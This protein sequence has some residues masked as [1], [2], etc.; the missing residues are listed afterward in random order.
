MIAIAKG[1][2]ICWLTKWSTIQVMTTTKPKRPETNKT[3]T[4]PDQTYNTTSQIVS[5]PSNN[6]T[7]GI[8][9]TTNTNAVGNNSRLPI[10]FKWL[11]HKR[12]FNVAN[13]VHFNY[14]YKTEEV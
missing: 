14:V 13:I 5:H 1:A 3:Q 11:K 7:K 9:T 4:E 8:T 10:D 12:M 2:N 6:A